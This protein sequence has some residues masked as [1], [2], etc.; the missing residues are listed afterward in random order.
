VRSEEKK[1]KK[2]PQILIYFQ[3]CYKLFGNSTKYF[4]NLLQFSKEYD[5]I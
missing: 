2:A 5:T 3:N 1:R 4:K